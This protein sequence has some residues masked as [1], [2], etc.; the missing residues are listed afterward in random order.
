MSPTEREFGA[1]VLRGGPVDDSGVYEMPSGSLP[2]RPSGDPS[3]ADAPRGGAAIAVT[4]V[5]EAEGSRAAAAALA[6]AGSEP[7]RAALLVECGQ[8]RRPRPTLLATAG[9]RALEERIAAHLPGIAVAA[10]GA[11]C[12]LGLDPDEDWPAALRAITPLARETALVVH[13]PAAR[14]QALLADPATTTDAV[15]LRA[16][17]PAERALTA[18]AASELIGRGLRVAVLRRRLAWPL[19][20][21]AMFGAL[22]ANTALPARMRARLLGE[23]GASAG[24]GR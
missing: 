11:T 24:E 9:A 13:L 4:A 2:T 12:Q 5:G 20:R 10:R 23:L 16:D 15:L 1:T 7:D 22:P 3:G 17:L 18:L 19:E 8:A 6:C 14:L 21:A